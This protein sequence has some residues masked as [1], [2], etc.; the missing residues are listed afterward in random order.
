MFYLSCKPFRLKKY[1]KSLSDKETKC[2]DI[3][4]ISSIA[5][6][7]STTALVLLKDNTFNFAEITTSGLKYSNEAKLKLIS[8]FN[9]SDYSLIYKN[10]ILY[11]F[12]VKF[13]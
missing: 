1:P 11:S 13:F 9:Q 2:P 7:N 5:R 3:L 8:K 4:S 12:K 6:L 10:N